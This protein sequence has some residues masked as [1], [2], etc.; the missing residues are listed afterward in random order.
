MRCTRYVLSADF[1]NRFERCGA[2]LDVVADCIDGYI[3]VF[4]R[5]PNGCFVANVAANCFDAR[6]ILRSGRPSD[7]DTR[8]NSGLV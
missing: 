7:G 1:V 2:L 3:T 6:S 8:D 5:R 4:K